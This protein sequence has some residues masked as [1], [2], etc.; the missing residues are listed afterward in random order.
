MVGSGTGLGLSVS[1]GIVEEHGGRL[2]VQSRPRRDDLHAGAAGD[3][4]ARTGRARAASGRRAPSGDRPPGPGGGGRAERAR[5]DRHAAE[6]ARAGRWTW[7]RA[8]APGCES[9]RQQRRY[10]LII[11]DIAHARRR[12]PDV[13]PRGARPRRPRSPGASSSSPATPPT[14]RPGRSSRTRSVP[15]IEKPFPPAVFEDAVARVIGRVV[16]GRRPARVRSSSVPGRRRRLTVVVT[17]A[18]LVDDPREALRRAPRAPP[19]ARCGAFLGGI[20]EWPAQRRDGDHQRLRDVRRRQRAARGRAG[21]RARAARSRSRPSRVPRFRAEPR[22]EGRD[23][24]GCGP[25]TRRALGLPSAR[26]VRYA[27]SAVAMSRCWG[28]V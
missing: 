2:S 4:S 6:G 5:P 7:P 27:V 22:A 20:R 26:R 1:Y 23:P 18:E 8:A 12:R 17:K 24:L 21:I 19:S 9:R 28:I 15:V 10:D 16:D 14:P 3:A 11:S 25:R 13:L